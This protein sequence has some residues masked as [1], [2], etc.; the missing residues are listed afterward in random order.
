MK[1]KP[2]LSNST[3]PDLDDGQNTGE[4]EADKPEEETEEQK[5]AREAEEEQKKAK[6]EEAKRKKKNDN[7]LIQNFVTLK[8][9]HDATV[10]QAKDLLEALDSDPDYKWAAKNEILIAP[11]NKA[12]QGI[13]SLKNSTPIWK[14]WCI[15][16]KSKLLLVNLD[17][18]F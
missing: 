14:A 11:V 18:S 6:D 13:Q 15:E 3:E 17:D 9:T 8:K 12:L 4:A 7:T 1:K 10:Q 5:K 2:R 16:Q